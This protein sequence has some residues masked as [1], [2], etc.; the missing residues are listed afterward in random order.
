MPVRRIFFAD[1]HYYHVYSRCVEGL[2]PFSNEVIAK[3]LYQLLWFYRFNSIDCSF[4]T[5]LKKKTS[6]RNKILLVINKSEKRVVVICYCIMP[7]HFHLL[8]KQTNENGIVEYMHRSEDGISKY[9]NNLDNRSGVVFQSRFKAKLIDSEPYFTHLSRY[10]H[11][12]PYSSG[13]IKGVNMYKWSSLPEYAMGQERLCDTGAIL[14]IFGSR[15]SYMKF[16]HDRA[17]YQRDLE[18]N[19]YEV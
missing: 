14:K 18:K 3:R 7:T 5:F 11:L 13:L 15:N 9:I 2:S 12:N 19:K 1:Q 8:L 4:S 6:E 16:I 17:S 10:I